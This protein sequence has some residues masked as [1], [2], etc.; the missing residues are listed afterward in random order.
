MLSDVFLFIFYFYLIFFSII[1]YGFLFCRL[2]KI[3][4]REISIG[5]IGLV[6]VFFLTL[7]SYLTIIFFPHN[8]IHNLI[9]VLTG[10]LL[11]AYEFFDVK[12]I[13]R[14][15]FIKSSLIALI[16]ISG[17]FIS[18]N[19][20]DFGYYHFAYIVS[21]T[22]NKVQF[23]LA[24]YNSGFGTH[25]SIFYFTSSLYLPLINYYLFNVHGLLI[26]IFFNIFLLDNFFFRKKK[27]IN[28]INIL[29]LFAFVY[30]NLLFSRL[31]EY[32]TDRAGQMVVFLIIILYLNISIKKFFFEDGIKI[33]IILICY[34]I[35]I[36]SYFLAYAL[37]FPLVWIKLNN[38]S[39][40][41]LI[42]NINLI[43]TLFLFL[44]L[45]LFI[46]IANTGCLIYPLHLTCFSNFFWS[47]PLEYVKQLNQWF[48]LWSKAGATPNYVV[49]DRF[50]YLQN[51]HWVSNWINKYFFT[52]VTDTLGAIV[53]IITF[54]LLLFKSNKF[55]KN[56]ILP[57]VVV[58]YSVI[59]FFFIVW[60]N[61]HPDLR[62]GGYVLISLLFFIPASVYFS[63]YNIVYRYNNLRILFLVV[64][65]L[66][67]FNIR[68]YLRIFS[69]FNRNDPYQFNNF[70]FFSQ[71]YLNTRMNFDLLNQ[72]IK[73][74]GYNFYYTKKVLTE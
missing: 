67:S 22:E 68:N 19:N 32:G 18:K 40:I 28:F 72:P 52:K 58:L 41:F 70:P 60:F 74:M 36:K 73:I 1:G 37:L 25:S 49:Q 4:L 6:G 69:E 13:F 31:A 61:K 57:N 10:I 38:Y 26:L 15:Q 71:Q 39:K 63:K 33:I 2:S 24:N 14:K 12:K 17:L 46:N 16:F 5:I 64:V 65:I 3:N 51:F 43:L 23:G 48:E 55:K 42:R 54:F 8:Y 21:L 20:E 66:L 62:Y 45:F 34:A 29:S 47:V 53:A 59:I 9:I 50:E 7:I 35:S 44:F 56:N 11:V 27:N 30:F